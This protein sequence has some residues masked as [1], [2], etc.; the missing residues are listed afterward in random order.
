MR[1]QL[2]SG[3]CR[4]CH[5]AGMVL[6]THLRPPLAPQDVIAA[7]SA[8]AASG[9]SCMDPIKPHIQRLHVWWAELLGPALGQRAQRVWWKDMLGRVIGH[10]TQ[11]TGAMAL[12]VFGGSFDGDSAAAVLAAVRGSDAARLLRMLPVLSVLQDAGAWTG[13]AELLAEE[14][15]PPSHADAM[16]CYA[17]PCHGAQLPTARKFCAHWRCHAGLPGRFAMHHLH[18]EVAAALLRQRD[19]Y[20]A[21]AVDR[22]FVRRV[23]ALGGRLEELSNAVGKGTASAEEQ[24]L[25]WLLAPAGARAWQSKWFP[26]ASPDC[27]RKFLPD[28]VRLL[29]H[30]HP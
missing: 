6:H 16:P 11:L 18:R 7:G 10:R 26:G 23:F 13:E 19:P 28:W 2:V 3:H 14:H 20:V 15:R 12:S 25:S 1:L 8:V 4:H 5:F 22:A 9:Q 24:R 29:T 27:A 30:H 17:M 21:T